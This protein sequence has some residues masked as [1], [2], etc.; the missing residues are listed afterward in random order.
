ML[1]LISV[2]EEDKKKQTRQ[3]N[4]IARVLIDFNQC[5]RL[6]NCYDNWAIAVFQICRLLEMYTESRKRR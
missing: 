4:L 6:Q 1:M 5:T 3:N 2:M